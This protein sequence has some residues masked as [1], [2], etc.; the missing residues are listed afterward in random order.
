MLLKNME[1]LLD[2]LLVLTIR[3]KSAMFS[4]VRHSSRIIPAF[5]NSENISSGWTPEDTRSLKGLKRSWER[6][7][8]DL[9][10]QQNHAG[11]ERDEVNLNSKPE[12]AEH[13][14]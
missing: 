5:R 9:Q 8:S 4:R 14:K 11:W 13:L 12:L 3:F 7:L 10:S 1:K 6:L 2:R